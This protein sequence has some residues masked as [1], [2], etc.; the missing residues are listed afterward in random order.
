MG[1]CPILITVLKHTFTYYQYINSKDNST[2][3][4][5]ALHIV[6]EHGSV[7]RNSYINNL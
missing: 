4:K 5:Q 3:V 1:N 6:L 2:F 7:L